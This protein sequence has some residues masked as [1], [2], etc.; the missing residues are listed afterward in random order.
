MINIY[1]FYGGISTKLTAHV[2]HHEHHLGSGLGLVDPKR[3]F[4]RNIHV[5]ECGLYPLT[6]E[7]KSRSKLSLQNIYDSQVEFLDKKWRFETVC[8]K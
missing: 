8:S 1:L 4:G 5:D 6:L 2:R 7:Q 3:F